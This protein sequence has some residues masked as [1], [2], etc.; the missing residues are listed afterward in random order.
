MQSEQLSGP[1]IERWLL[2]LTNST[3]A[4]QQLKTAETII[5]DPRLYFRISTFGSSS[6]SRGTADSPPPHIEIESEHDHD[7][8]HNQHDDH[9]HQNNN[10]HRHHPPCSVEAS[11]EITK[12]QISQ[13]TFIMRSNHPRVHEV[14]WIILAALIRP[15]PTQPSSS[16]SAK[17]NQ[18]ISLIA[19]STSTTSQSH[20]SKLPN[21]Y[22]TRLKMLKESRFPDRALKLVIQGFHTGDSS[23]RHAACYFLATMATATPM[24]IVDNY[25]AVL[26]YMG[27]MIK[28]ERAKFDLSTITVA[29]IALDMMRGF[30]VSTGVVGGVGVGVVESFNEIEESKMDRDRDR[31]RTY[32]GSSELFTDV[33]TFVTCSVSEGYDDFIRTGIGI[34]PRMSFSAKGRSS[35]V[36]APG[37]A[38]TAAWGAEAPVESRH[39]L[40]WRGLISEARVNAVAIVKNFLKGKG[41]EAKQAVV[42]LKILPAL[43]WMLKFS[44]SHEEVLQ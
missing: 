30:S 25:T 3:E 38:P 6:T 31:I 35:T 10:S 15:P 41:R 23:P 26:S 43:L 9:T 12:T 36:G 42:E 20:P 4:D 17:S 5:K 7:H 24:D 37:G 39:P 21:S 33:C 28:S 40:H 11:Y 32:I 14:V 34:N 29:S 1:D 27:S 22:L 18:S 44:K 13:L 16:S 8:T 19:P 2:L